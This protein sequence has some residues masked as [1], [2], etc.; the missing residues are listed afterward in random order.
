MT[1]IA[2]GAPV[3][4]EQTLIY[5]DSSA[6][7]KLVIREAETA[8][9]RRFLRSRPRRVTSK[10]AGVE[11]R[12]TVRRYAAQPR[13]ER[14]AER[15]LSGVGQLVLDDDTLAIAA[16]LEPITLRSLDALH[17]AAAL[18]LGDDLDGMVTYDER[19]AG[20]AQQAGVVVY[21]PH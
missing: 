21:S 8:A 14:T 16:Q 11:V 15:V 9:L 6:L 18:S 12:R 20:A 1:D 2:P 17:L 10:L 19:L 4:G 13:A 7:V 3:S 5:L